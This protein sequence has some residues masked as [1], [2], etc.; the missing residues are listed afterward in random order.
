M[1]KQRISSSSQDLF[2]NTS[3]FCQCGNLKETRSQLDSLLSV[4]SS[5]SRSIL[6]GSCSARARQSPGMGRFWCHP[7]HRVQP[8]KPAACAAQT[9]DSEKHVKIRT[10]TARVKQVFKSFVAAELFGGLFLFQTPGEG[11]CKETTR[12]WWHLSKVRVQIA[13]MFMFAS[14]AL[15]FFFQ[16]MLKKDYPISDRFL[17]CHVPQNLCQRHQFP[18]PLQGREDLVHRAGCDIVVSKGKGGRLN[19]SRQILHIQRIYKRW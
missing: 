10:C 19:R 7:Q 3:P 14:T 6:C 16:G 5:Q 15:S 2:F 11:T 13:R 1:S 8:Q 18:S 4:V 12:C 9:H 17:L